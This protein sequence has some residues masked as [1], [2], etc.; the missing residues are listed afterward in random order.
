VVYSVFAGFATWWIIYLR[1]HNS[2]LASG[3]QDR[4]TFAQSLPIVL[5]ILAAFYATDVWKGA[6]EFE[7]EEPTPNFEV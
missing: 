3:S 4:W 2:M 6:F 1:I 7:N 5:L